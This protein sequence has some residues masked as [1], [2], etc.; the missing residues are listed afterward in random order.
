MGWADGVALF[1]WCEDNYVRTEYIAEWYNTWTALPFVVF[2]LLTTFALQPA[3][4]EWLRVCGCML[5]FFGIG[6]A[7]FHACLTRWGQA[8]DEL[9]ILYWEVSMLCCVFEQQ[10]QS[11]PKLY[12]FIGVLV[13]IETCVYFYMDVCAGLL[14]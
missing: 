8:M 5:V 11:Q 2:G 12:V 14:R 3:G 7:W 1:D 9:G 13:V 6:T 10:M 4:F